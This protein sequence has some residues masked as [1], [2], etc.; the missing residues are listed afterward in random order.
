MGWG[1]NGE[2]R[3]EEEE[4]RREAS[5]G[6]LLPVDPETIKEVVDITG[7]PERFWDGI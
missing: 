3:D 2:D 1:S 7:S 6:L 5:P 4:R